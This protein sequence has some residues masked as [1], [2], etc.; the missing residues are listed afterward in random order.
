MDL[1]SLVGQVLTDDLLYHMRG[2]HTAVRVKRP[3][4]SYTTE[5]KPFRLNIVVDDNNIIT[6]YHFG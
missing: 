2:T 4:N 6:G 5:S 3:G 1:D